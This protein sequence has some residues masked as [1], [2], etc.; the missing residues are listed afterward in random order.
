MS[1][2]EDLALTNLLLSRIAIDEDLAYQEKTGDFP[3]PS[4]S[5]SSQK[6]E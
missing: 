4:M 2:P 1:H 3:S 5:L 6:N